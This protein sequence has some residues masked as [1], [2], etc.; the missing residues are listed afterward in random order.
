MD[1]TESCF[2]NIIKYKTLFER[3]ETNDY[4][5]I[6][7]V[8]EL[9]NHIE[10]NSGGCITQQGLSIL[11]L[12]IG[13]IS[14]RVNQGVQNAIGF[15]DN[16]LLPQREITKF[17]MYMTISYAVCVLFRGM[18][19]IAYEPNSHFLENH[20]FPEF[21]S[22]DFKKYGDRAY[23]LVK[24]FKEG[25]DYHSK[26]LDD[27]HRKIYNDEKAF[28]FVKQIFTPKF[29]HNFSSKGLPVGLENAREVQ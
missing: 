11:N 4:W 23:T 22:N 29:T 5:F 27:E 17:C 3:D 9:L 7:F 1:N 25:M 15:K 13:S 10:R 26:L 16:S 24:N 8:A 2:D 18:V 28:M 19:D 20:N 14:A 12:D 21:I 6:L